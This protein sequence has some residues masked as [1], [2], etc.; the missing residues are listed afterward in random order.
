LDLGN[1]NKKNRKRT[2]SDAQGKNS[3]KASVNGRKRN[4]S[5]D[6]KSLITYGKIIGNN[7]FFNIV[8]L[9]KININKIIFFFFSTREQKRKGEL[10]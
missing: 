3:G 5:Y 1:K 4:K 9:I 6:K 7:F 8:K 2:Q 10:N